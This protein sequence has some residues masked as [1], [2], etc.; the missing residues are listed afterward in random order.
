MQFGTEKTTFPLDSKGST[1]ST[2][3]KYR[4]G[5][6]EK[7]LKHFRIRVHVKNSQDEMT[8][9]IRFTDELDRCR[10]NGTLTSD[11]EDASTKPAFI[12]DYPKENIDGSYF[13]IKSYCLFDIR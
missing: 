13:I 11:R 3:N 12:I 4:N 2:I 5:A 10:K 9:F 8:E 1:I 6:V 7:A